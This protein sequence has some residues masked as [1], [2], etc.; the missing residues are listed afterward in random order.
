MRAA[1]FGSH[2]VRLGYWPSTADGTAVEPRTAYEALNRIRQAIELEA[3]ALLASHSSAHWLRELRQLP[4]EAFLA[5]G[6]PPAVGVMHRRT[7]E[8]LSHLAPQ[9]T[10]YPAAGGSGGGPGADPR[11]LIDLVAMAVVLQKVHVGLRLAGKD[12]ALLS[13][14]DLDLEARWTASQADAV[15]LYDSRAQAGDTPFMAVAGLPLGEHVPDLGTVGEL[16]VLLATPRRLGGDRVTMERWGRPDVHVSH[17]IGAFDLHPLAVLARR[18]A[19][20]GT[21]VVPAPVRALAVL[22]RAVRLIFDEQMSGAAYA[23]L[24]HGMLESE[25]PA[26]L[27]SYIGRTLDFQRQLFPGTEPLSVAG[28]ADAIADDSLVGNAWPVTPGPPMRID[29][30][31]FVLDVVACSL[32]LNDRLGALTSDD[33]LA[34]QRGGLFELA[35]QDLIDRSPWGEVPEHLRALTGQQLQDVTGQYVTDLDAIGFRDGRLLLV[36]CLSKVKNPGRHLMG[37]R[38]VLLTDARR[39]EVKVSGP[40]HQPERAWKRKCA[41]LVGQ[42][43]RNFDLSQHTEA[44]CVVVTP[45]P[46]YVEAAFIGRTHVEASVEA[47]DGLLSA[48]SFAE[49]ARWLSD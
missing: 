28:W 36:D 1:A 2:L 43:G 49:F 16:D 12:I 5:P 40:P 3:E 32:L 9:Q 7:A 33:G 21:S 10:G 30:R 17:S 45:V 13:H 46:V 39:V 31:S 27:G 6:E 23:L 34:K 8:A 11:A 25:S 26:G 19:T 15:A 14:D 38:A 41:R 18:M 48:A 37:D 22:L 42:R 29:E 35:V 4:G 44:L 47:V 24:A 20:G